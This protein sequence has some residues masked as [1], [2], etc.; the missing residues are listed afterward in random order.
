M[1]QH[2]AALPHFLTE[3]LGFP[4]AFFGV[5]VLVNTVVIAVA[6]VPL[7]IANAG[8]PNR[9][10]IAAGA[11]LFG[12]GFGLFGLVRS[13]PEAILAVLIF[14]VGEMLAAPAAAAYVADRGRGEDAGV[15][16]SLYQLGFAVALTIGP[17]LG[18]VVLE[19]AGP[20]VLWSGT[21]AA[22]LLSA[23]AVWFLLRDAPPPHSPAANQSR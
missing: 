9:S 10:G 19:S 14:T 6:E 23:V 11:L 2:T 20:D 7:N 5:L 3:H 18:I 22:G 17:A 12:A 13:R 1:V 4:P 16:M 21:L 8:W 15:Y